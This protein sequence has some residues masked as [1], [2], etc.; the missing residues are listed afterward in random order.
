MWRRHQLLFKKSHILLRLDHQ[1]KQPPKKNEDTIPLPPQQ[2]RPSRNKNQ[3]RAEE[4]SRQ[5]G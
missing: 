4:I 5:K 2:R 1:R 3:Q